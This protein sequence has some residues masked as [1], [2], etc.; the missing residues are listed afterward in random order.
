MPDTPTG[1]D[2]ARTVEEMCKRLHDA[3][4]AAGFLVDDPMVATVKKPGGAL[5]EKVVPP[6]FSSGDTERL[7]KIL[8][9]ARR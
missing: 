1:T 7:C 2:H 6:P 4:Q 8:E 3:L 5:V 9:A